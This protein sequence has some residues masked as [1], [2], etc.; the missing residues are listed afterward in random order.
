M[1]RGDDTPAHIIPGPTVRTLASAVLASSVLAADVVLLTLFLNPEAALRRDGLAL[2]GSLFLPYAVAGALALAAGAVV[3][4][5]LRGSAV[6]GARPRRDIVQGLPGFGGMVLAA[7]VLAAALFWFNLF[8]YRH[9]IP[10]VS[11]RA[12]AVA[13]AVV[14]A[15][16]LV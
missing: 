3:V 12:L 11:L 5:A 8:S 7:L 9:S 15:A 10:L 16:A 2:L 14:S 4:G 13:S 1:R 6:P